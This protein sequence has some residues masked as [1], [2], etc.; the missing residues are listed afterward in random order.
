MNV[1]DK[2]FWE[3][4]HKDNDRFWLTGTNLESIKHFHN[5]NTEDL[6]N[7]K[8]L[9]IGVG[10]GNLSKELV[11]YSENIICCDISEES[12]KNVDQKVNKKY[13]T[14]ELKKIEPVD[15]AICHLV[16]QHCTNDEIERIIKEVNLTEGG[17]FTFQFAYLR[18]NEKPNSKVRDFINLGS[19]HFRD[20]SQIR[21]IV[22]KSNKKIVWISKSY[23]FSNP[24]NF[25]WL[26]VKIK[27]NE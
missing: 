10:L 19:H 4:K 7:K 9:E 11:N 16:F 1:I 3:K 27:N 25:S 5:L 20:I 13:L 23:D 2:S 26:I 18:E 22:N 14:T 15:I 24:E 17:V 21:D 12:L 6:K 8:I